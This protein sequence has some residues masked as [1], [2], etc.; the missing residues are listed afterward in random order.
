VTITPEVEGR[1]LKIHHDVGDT[2]RPGDT[3]LELDPADFRLAV[4]EARRGLERELAKLG[5]PTRGFDV[6]ALQHGQGDPGGQALS[7]VLTLLVTPVACSLFDSVG[8]WFRRGRRAGPTAAAARAEP[9]A[10][11]EVSPVAV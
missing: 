9:V 6:I 3:L 2:V 8:Q 7:L 4:A 11:T 5:R 10:V 1:V